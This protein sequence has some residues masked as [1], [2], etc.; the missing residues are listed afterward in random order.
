MEGIMTITTITDGYTIVPPPGEM[1]EDNDRIEAIDA[2]GVALCGAYRP[3]G[4]DYWIFFVTQT[5][6]RITGLN[7]PP[8]KEHFYGQSGRLAVLAWVELIA[9]LATLAAQAQREVS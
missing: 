2:E 9:C 7:T 5:V 3:V 4:H 8:H 1:T 6:T